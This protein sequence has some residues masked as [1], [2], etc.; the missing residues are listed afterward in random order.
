MDG[1]AHALKCRWR[2]TADLQSIATG[3]IFGKQPRKVKPMFN[4]PRAD[5]VRELAGSTTLISEKNLF[6]RSWRQH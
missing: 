5:L 2:S 6:R 3:G 1:Q 4:L